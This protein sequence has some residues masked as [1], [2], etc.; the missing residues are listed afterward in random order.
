MPCR[1]CLG[2]VSFGKAVYDVALRRTGIAEMGLLGSSVLQ[3][4]HCLAARGG[5]NWMR[6][7][8]VCPCL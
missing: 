7:A 1:G 2:V 4:I 6:I 3:H 8:V 5:C